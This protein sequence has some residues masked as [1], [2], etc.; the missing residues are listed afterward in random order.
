[1]D[2]DLTRPSV[3]EVF[4]IDVKSG[5]TD[6]FTRGVPLADCLVNPGLER[7]VLL[8]AGT[9]SRH[10]SELLG[11]TMMRNLFEELT[12]RYPER[13][14]LFDLPPVLVSDDAISF[15]RNTGCCALFVMEAG[16]SRTAE[17]ERAFELL[18]DCLV[19]GTV[20]NKVKK[21]DHKY[22]YGYGY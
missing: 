16:T 20:L 7:L 10:S 14:I 11:S 3:H 5:L 9:V 19:I 17:A 21:R 1:V 12:A 8:P 22:Y 15:L 18:E 4:G 2:L 6:H 13:I